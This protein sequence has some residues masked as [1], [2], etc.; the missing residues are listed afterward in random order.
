MTTST[1]YY[2]QDSGY[3]FSSKSATQDLYKEDMKLLQVE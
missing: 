1:V 2:L 3:F